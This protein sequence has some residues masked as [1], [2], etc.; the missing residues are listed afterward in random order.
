MPLF[1]KS[2]ISKYLQQLDQAE[3]KTAYD[4]FKSFYGDKDLNR[5]NEGVT[6]VELN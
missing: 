2:V 6:I 3:L 4:K 1:Q 5:E